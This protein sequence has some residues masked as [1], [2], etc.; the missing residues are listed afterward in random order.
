MKVVKTEVIIEVPDNLDS[1]EVN[2]EIER[3]INNDTFFKV[4]AFGDYTTV[5]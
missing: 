1:V 4:V 5:E 3:A 2:E